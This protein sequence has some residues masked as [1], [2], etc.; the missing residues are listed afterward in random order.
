VVARRFQHRKDG[1]VG[2]RRNAVRARLGVVH[3]ALG[4]AAG[5]AAQGSTSPPR[6]WTLTRFVTADRS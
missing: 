5:D 1:A 2:R 4:L 6:C 3:E